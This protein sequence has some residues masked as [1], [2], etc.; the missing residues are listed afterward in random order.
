MNITWYV[1]AV[2]EEVTIIF[3]VEE[4]TP[5]LSVANIYAFPIDL[6]IENVNVGAVEPQLWVT[7]NIVIG[8]SLEIPGSKVSSEDSSELTFIVYSCYISQDGLNNYVRLKSF[9]MLPVEESAVNTIPA[10]LR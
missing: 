8:I 10:K 7:V 9:I 4:S 2:R 1:P 6:K 3:P 5:I